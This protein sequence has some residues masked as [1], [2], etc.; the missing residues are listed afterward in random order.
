MDS[1]ETIFD[2]LITGID[3]DSIGFSKPVKFTDGNIGISVHKEYSKK[4]LNKMQIAG[5]EKYVALI[6]LRLEKIDDQE[7]IPFNVA[8]RFLH[9]NESDKTFEYEYKFIKNK[10]FIPSEIISSREFYLDTKGKN[11]FRK[12]HK[13]IVVIE[14][15]DIFSMIFE[16][17]LKTILFH[18]RIVTFIKKDFYKTLIDF[19]KI[20][21]YFL[22]K[23]LKIF[24]GDKEKYDKYRPIS[25]YFADKYPEKKEAT[26]EIKNDISFYGFKVSKHRLFV[27][28]L[29]HLVL[30]FISN[31]IS[32]LGNFIK[33]NLPSN[34]IFS[35]F[36]IVVAWIL[37]SDLIPYIIRKTIHI[38]S[39]I[40]YNLLMKN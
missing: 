10:S 19:C 13:S 18:R 31:R 1:K 28:C 40:T 36:Y 26:E 25:K 23:I 4:L 32:G 9:Y 24:W 29:I 12:I 2:N 33:N 39:D 20:N 35:V 34:S 11:F 22:E 21:G 16:Q 17:H 8:C 14:G 6:H 3:F 7:R 5:N 37:Y 30:F 38:Y 15:K 27:F